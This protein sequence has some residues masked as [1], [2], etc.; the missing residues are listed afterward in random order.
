MKKTVQLFCLLI[1]IAAALP[2]YA[3]NKVVVIPLN[4]SKG[5]PGNWNSVSAT[6]LG[7]TPRTSTV[8][9]KQGTTCTNSVGRYATSGSSEFLTVPIQLP[10]GATITAFTAVICDNTAT[11][12]G[13]MYLYRSDSTQIATTGTSSAESSTTVYTKTTTTINANADVV[14][15]SQYSY[16]IYMEIN[17]TAG[18]DL[19]PI[20]GIVTLQ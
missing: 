14:D 5:G 13:T 3:Q 10:D 12:S 18:N 19:I 11:A 15:N 17:G 4:S 20:S 1:L 9:T 16:Y 8:T 7:G 6:S 2:T